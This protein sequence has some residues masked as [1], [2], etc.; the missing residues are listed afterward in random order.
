M[1]ASQ[2]PKFFAVRDSITAWRDEDKAMAHQSWGPF[3]G[4]DAARTALVEAMREEAEWLRMSDRA[5]AIREAAGEVEGL[6]LD[7]IDVVGL[8]WKVSPGRW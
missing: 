7:T 1:T 4:L 6:A 8:R 2:T 3:S 5:D